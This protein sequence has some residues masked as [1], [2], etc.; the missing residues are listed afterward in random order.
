MQTLWQDLL[1]EQR[2]GLSSTP[3][4]P[5]HVRSGCRSQRRG[6]EQVSIARVQQIAW[7][8]VD[9]W[10][11]KAATWCRRFSQRMI[12]RIEIRELQSDEICTLVDG[13]DQLPVWIFAAIEVWSR[14]W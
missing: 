6:C 8:T 12:T 5:S 3:A 13:K 1:P 11:E 14:L 4:S 2:H 10:L 7:N 9:H